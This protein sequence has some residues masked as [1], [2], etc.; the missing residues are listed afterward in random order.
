MTSAEVT[1]DAGR[2]CRRRGGAG[3]RRPAP[4]AVPRVAARVRAAAA[5]E[6]AQRIAAASVRQEEAQVGWRVRS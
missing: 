4:R 5:A 3:D 1:A 6:A 2:R